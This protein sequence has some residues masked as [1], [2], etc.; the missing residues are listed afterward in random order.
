MTSS[1]NSLPEDGRVVIIGGG[2][3]G[4]ACA[5]APGLR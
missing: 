2:P 5:L 4:T 1:E 3:G